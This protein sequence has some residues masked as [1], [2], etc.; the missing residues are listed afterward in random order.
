MKLE[1]TAIINTC[2]VYCLRHHFASCRFLIL[3]KIHNQS[4]GV[5]NRMSQTLINGHNSAAGSPLSVGI[6]IPHN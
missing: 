6:S 1:I 2:E 5:A 3:T 4:T